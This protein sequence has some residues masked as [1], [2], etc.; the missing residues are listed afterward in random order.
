MSGLYTIPFSGL[1]EGRH[2]FDFKIG[3]EFFEQFEESEI[4]EGN[5]VVTVEI[6]KLS[7]HADMAIRITGD[8]R[9]CCDR[10]LG[11]F[12]QPI[13]CENRIIVEFGKSMED[14]DPDIISVPADNSELDLRQHIYEFI[15]LALPIKR[16]HPDDEKGNSTCD[17]VMLKKLEELTIEDENE[18]DPRWDELKKLM[19]DN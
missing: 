4:K 3:D 6:E 14:I 19:N 8:V 15:N 7:T 10:C 1:K 11:M 13:I 18:E 17:P 12:F 2:L 9:I 5:L 16:V